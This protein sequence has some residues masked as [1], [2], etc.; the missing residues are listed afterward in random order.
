M[1]NK[2]EL[3]FILKFT[4]MS[5]EFDD[6]PTELGPKRLQCYLFFVF[7]FAHVIARN[8]TK[9]SR[10]AGKRYIGFFLFVFQ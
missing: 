9:P 6:T 2:L 3:T 4:K 10:A 1:N 7:C 8:K 5:I